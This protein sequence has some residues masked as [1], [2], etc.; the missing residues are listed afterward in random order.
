MNYQR[1]IKQ[2]FGH[3]ELHGGDDID[4]QGQVFLEKARQSGGE[5]HR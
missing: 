5:D 4:K 1:G 3:L 2:L